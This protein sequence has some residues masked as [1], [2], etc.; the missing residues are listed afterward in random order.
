MQ[1]SGLALQGSLLARR[2]MTS[3]SP[4]ASGD[5]PGDIDASQ[6]MWT[7]G[8]FNYWEGGSLC[9][10]AGA[11]LAVLSAQEAFGALA[12]LD[13]AVRWARKHDMHTCIRAS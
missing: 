7:D 2:S 6:Y 4:F 10:S 12:S 9:G 3:S 13:K 1:G 11:T 5:P 8:V